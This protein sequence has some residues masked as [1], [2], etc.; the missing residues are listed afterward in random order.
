MFPGKNI[1]IRSVFSILILC[2]WNLGFSQTFI[3]GNIYLDSTGY[4]AYRAGNLPL[5]ISSP[6][7]GSLQPDSIPDR[8]CSGCVTVGDAYTKTIAEGMYDEIFKKTGCYP[9]VIINLLHR[10]KI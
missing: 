6:H 9:H 2:A 7:G 4:V 10:K 5:I 3:P 8:T 1:T